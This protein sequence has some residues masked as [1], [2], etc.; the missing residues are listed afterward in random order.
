[1]FQA[2][3][4]FQAELENTKKERNPDNIVSDVLVEHVHENGVLPAKKQQKEN[5]PLIPM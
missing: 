1:M 4:L 2:A 3:F 5:T